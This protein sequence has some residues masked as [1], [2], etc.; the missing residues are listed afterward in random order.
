M[1]VLVIASAGSRG[2]VGSCCV[3]HPQAC[4]ATLAKPSSD[5]SHNL[6]ASIQHR[7]FSSSRFWEK[8]YARGGNSGAGSYGKLAMYK[9]A[10][11]NKFVA[12]HGVETVA[13]FGCG[14]GNQLS[15][16]I[17]VYPRYIGFDVSETVLRRLRSRFV[18]HASKAAFFH[19]SAFNASVHAS[20]LVLSLDVIFHLV[21]DAIFDEYMGRLLAAAK[22]FVVIYSSNEDRPA[23][24]HVRHRSF[25]SWIDRRTDGP[26]LR[27]IQHEKHPMGCSLEERGCGDSGER[28]FASFWVYRRDEGHAHG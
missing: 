9:K 25:S 17:N 8:R 2:C 26:R 10:F 1:L 7:G 15:L 19:V 28:S 11:I 14:D 3:R 18:R 27:L 21:E 13:E 22:R 4:A 5:R 23:R 12:A 24:G 16:S 6:T 20:D